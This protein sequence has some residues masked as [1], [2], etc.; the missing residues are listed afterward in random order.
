MNT[1]GIIR[2]I[3]DLG[4]IVIP[5]DIREHMKIKENDPF[6]IYCANGNIILKRY[7]ID[8]IEQWHNACEAYLKWYY[9]NPNFI[10]IRFIYRNRVTSCIGFTSKHSKHIGT[11][12]WNT[13]EDKYDPIIGQAIALCRAIHGNTCD[14]RNLIGLEG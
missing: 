9:E 2:R 8:I 12:K 4:R 1:I 7:N 10:D 13:L 11:S 5:R 6:E 14:F 3:D